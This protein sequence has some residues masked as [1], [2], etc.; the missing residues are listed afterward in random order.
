MFYNY[1]HNFRNAF[2]LANFTAFV[3]LNTFENILHYNIGRLSEKKNIQFYYPNRKDLVRI[4][5]IMV[6]FGTLQALLTGYIEKIF[7]KL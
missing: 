1:L 5:I 3:I 4:I 2:F 6:I 7:I